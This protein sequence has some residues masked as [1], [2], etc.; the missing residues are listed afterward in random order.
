[1]DTPT[2]HLE[3]PNYP[4]DYQSNKEC[5]WKLTAPA[6][7]QVALKFQSF[8]IENHDQCT[9]DFVEI[10]DGHAPDSPI[11]GTFCGYK[12]PPDI[13]SSGTKL[14]IK[15]VSDGSVQKPGFSAVFMKEFDECALEDHG[16]EHICKNVLGGYECH[17]K[18]GYELHSDGK[19]CVDACGGILDT[20]NG[21]L[22]SPSFPDFYI[23]N[24]TCIWEIVAPPQYRISLNFTHFDIEGNNLFQSSCEYDNLTVF[25][26]IGDNS[27]KS[28][29]VYCGSK[30][31]PVIMS[32]GN[33]LRIEFHSDNSVQKSG[34]SAYYFTDKD[35][36][37]TNNGGCQH[38][39]RN[40]IGSYVCSCHNG[41]TLLENGHDCKEGGCKYEITTPTGIIKTPNHPDYYPSKR[42]CIWHFTTTPGHRIKLVFQEFE[43]EPHQTC[44]YDHVVMY[45][46]DSP[47]SLTLG[48][49]CGVKVP[50]PIITGSN[51]LYM[52]FKSDA[53]V[54]RKG[55]IA[56]HT[57]GE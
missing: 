40:T 55:F 22:T 50:Y 29:G 35:E 26:R 54:Q 10:R 36:C 42:E 20:P 47:D 19:T 44:A 25:S 39:C 49:F 7:F 16:C 24:K 31:P 46:G 33:A 41:Y 23:K 14:M 21:T 56:T 8:E 32:E 9:Y 5:V 13:K 27:F 52:M 28:Q 48:R 4:E 30:L 17:C 3:S 2:G 53:S 12:L 15:F 57:T 38:E 45:D 6:E 34:F 37:M 18:I 11:I 43:L 1:M 51:Q